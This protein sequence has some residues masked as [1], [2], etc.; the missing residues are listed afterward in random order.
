MRTALSQA[1]ARSFLLAAQGLGRGRRGRPTPA[2]VEGAISRMGA[3][4]IDTIHV[5]ARSPYLVLWSRLGDYDPAWL[6]DLLA[7]GRLFEYWAHA[8]CFLPADDF[9]WYRQRMLDNNYR[10]RRRSLDWLE[11]NR[12]LATSVLRRIRDEGPLRS[13]DFENRDGP[14]GRWWART[15][16]KLALEVLFNVGE[17]MVA[18]R[19]NFQRVYDLRERVRPGWDDARTPSAEEAR[20]ALVRRSVHALGAARPEWIA[21]YLFH[22]LPRRPVLET[23]EAMVAAGDLATVSIDGWPTPAIV[24]PAHLEAIDGA[25][26]R[27]TRRPQT[28]LLSPFDPIVWD[29]GRAL[30]LFGFDYRI[31]SYTRPL[32]R[33][34]GYFSLPILHGDAIVGRLDPKAHRK[35]G[36]FEVKSLH[37]EPQVRVTTALVDGLRSALE[38]CAAWHGTPEVVVRKA[39]APGLA[40]ALS[41]AP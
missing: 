9:P 6:D 18:R 40:T 31:E 41:I 1:D 14:G 28:T 20:G 2:E 15:A 22:N 37:L 21:A 38:R 29:R 4:Q 19:H 16:E 26:P 36:V 39:N 34:Y 12:D 11:A 8:A 3:L 10:L 30:D 23:I 7:G 35:R 25:R 5:V 27:H 33:K 32:H 13:A 24:D 17:L